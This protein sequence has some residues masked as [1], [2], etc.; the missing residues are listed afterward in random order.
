[1]NQSTLR[2]ICPWL[3]A[4]VAIAVYVNAIANGFA[5]DDEAIVAHNPLVHSLAGL[6][7]AWTSPYWPDAPANISLY[8]P[9]TIATYAIEWVVWH[10]HPAGFHLVNVLLHAGVSALVVMLMLRLGASTAGAALGG[11]L[12]AIHPVHVEAVAGIVGR[13]EV[14]MTL[15]VVIACLVHLER[16]WP[17]VVRWLIA[18]AC[19]FAALLTKESAVAL[20]LLLLIVDAVDRTRRETMVKR[21]VDDAPLY[22]LLAGAFVFYLLLRHSVLGVY[23]GTNVA[24][25][26]EQ[27]S[28]ATRLATAMRVWLDY[29]RLMLFPRDLVADY[30]PNVIVPASW[31]QPGV[32]AG[33]AL[34]VA[35]MLSALILRRRA[36][37]WAAGVAWFVAGMFIVS[38]VVI[39][40]GIVLAE[41]NFYLPSIAIAFVAAP[42]PEWIAA[43][44]RPALSRS[45]MALAAIVVAAAAV[46]TWTRTPVWRSTTTLLTDLAAHH[47]ESYRAQ[48]FLGDLAMRRN[49]AHDAATHYSSAYGMV[50]NPVIAESYAAALVQLRNWRDAER[51]A[52]AACRIDYPS[53]CLYLID[54]LMAEGKPA[55]AKVVVDS[56]APHVAPSAAM[57]ARKARVDSAMI[58]R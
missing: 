52:G 53:P 5:L 20:P 11:L 6:G 58:K 14:L 26:L 22:L 25:G 55:E 57:A 47:P 38:N 50:P 23:G 13:A 7:R 40:V 46:R 33:L 39:P 28:V 54:A 35:V 29:A 15:L 18:A 31:T 34:G 37:W 41:R 2:R 9:V 17:R 42:I 45:V 36:P 48:S 21:V 43:R 10:G 49:D 56:I 3:V 32:W 1:M 8:R 30:S 44:R 4:G 27:A 19:Y 16:D 24:A 51:V 12:F